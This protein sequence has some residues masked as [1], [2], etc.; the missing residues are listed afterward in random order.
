MLIHAGHGTQNDI[1]SFLTSILTTIETDMSLVILFNFIPFPW[2]EQNKCL[3]YVDDIVIR[4]GFL[5]DLVSKY[6]MI[7]W[8]W[9]KK[10]KDVSDMNNST[11]I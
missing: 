7:W 2:D 6:G 4:K 5:E 9:W 11:D 10:K 1:W 3:V 8:W